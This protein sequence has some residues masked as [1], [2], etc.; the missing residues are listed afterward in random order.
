VTGFDAIL[1]PTDHVAVDWQL[2]VSNAKFMLDTGM[3]VP[4][5]T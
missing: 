5:A 1:V 2:V 4:A 3:S